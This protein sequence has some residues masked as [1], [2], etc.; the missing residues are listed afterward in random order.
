MV[1]FLRALRLPVSQRER[2]WLAHQQMTEKTDEALTPGVG[3]RIAPSV[4]VRHLWRPSR[5][6]GPDQVEIEILAVLAISTRRC[7]AMQVL[8]KVCH[9]NVRSNRTNATKYRT[10]AQGRRLLP[11]SR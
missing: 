9:I 2:E 8:Q 5:L 6:V 10:A 7:L 4:T 1:P 11:V 3:P